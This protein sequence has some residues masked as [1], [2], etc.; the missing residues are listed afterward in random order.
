M[1]FLLLF[2][3]SLRKTKV[4]LVKTIKTMGFGILGFMFGLTKGPWGFAVLTTE[5]RSS[6]QVSQPKQVI[7]LLR[8]LLGNIFFSRVLKQIQVNVS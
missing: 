5:I 3:K 6:Q 1:V 4:F 2:F 7:Y 8:H